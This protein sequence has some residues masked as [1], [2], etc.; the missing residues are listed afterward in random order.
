MHVHPCFINDNNESY[1][2]SQHHLYSWLC[3]KIFDHCRITCQ[4]CDEAY[5]FTINKAPLKTTG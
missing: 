1:F 5:K 2:E 4:R 3:F